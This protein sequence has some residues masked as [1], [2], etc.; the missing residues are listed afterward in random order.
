MVERCPKVCFVDRC[1]PNF[2]EPN[3]SEGKGM[4]NSRPAD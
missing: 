1:P 2:L 3:E 4:K